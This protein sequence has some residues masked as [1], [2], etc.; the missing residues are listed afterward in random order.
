MMCRSAL[1]LLICVLSACGG[2]GGGSGDFGTPGVDFGTGVGSRPPSSPENPPESPPE[3]PAEGEGDE[4]VDESPPGEL[5]AYEEPLVTMR[6][7]TVQWVA[8]GDDGDAGSVA[9]YEITVSCAA[10]AECP[11]AVT[12]NESLPAGEI[13][14]HTA[15][16]IS[17]GAEVTIIIQAFDDAD[18][19]SNQL[20]FNTRT[21]EANGWSF[22]NLPLDLSQQ[23]GQESRAIS[24]AFTESNE[25]VAAW[26]RLDEG[27]A[28]LNWFA[29][30]RSGSWVVE[31]LPV[32]KGG[33]VF[34]K[35]MPG[36]VI[37]ILIRS[38]DRSSDFIAHSFLMH[39]PLGGFGE[40]DAIQQGTLFT[41]NGLTDVLPSLALA[42]GVPAFAY[43]GH[44]TYNDAEQRSKLAVRRR[45]ASADW[46]DE[47]V[48]VCPNPL[49]SSVEPTYRFY[50]P[51]DVLRLLTRPAS[52]SL[53]LPERLVVIADFEGGLMIAEQDASGEWQ[54]GHTGELNLGMRD[55]A[56]SADGGSIIILLD[57]ANLMT[58]D[59]DALQP[60]GAECEL[61]EVNQDFE[62]IPLGDT[63]LV[64]ITVGPGQIHALSNTSEAPTNWRAVEYHAHCGDGW[65]SELLD[66]FDGGFS[67][68]SP[69]LN[70]SGDIAFLYDDLTQQAFYYARRQGNACD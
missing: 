37:G 7:I 16:P 28:S 15:R 45:V 23:Q 25:P 30:R 59:P 3:A 60:L 62:Q 1:M 46:T 26:E 40:P 12:R 33:T 52:P 50:V 17:P 61:P 67:S 14:V 53:G 55:A 41:E 57:G 49:D 39:D 24:V 2:G 19:P 56:L 68:L 69:I 43:V 54:V 5:A 34:M 64:S 13:E 66:I 51:F 21:L 4:E 18:N 47:T 42:D 63:S 70:Q 48:V 58:I 65:A 35:T 6:S 32:D 20:T 36:D 38:F 8:P 44:T 22:E 9:R 27:L 29:D 31:R 10:A 11:A